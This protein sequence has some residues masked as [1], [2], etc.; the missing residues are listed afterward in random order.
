MIDLKTVA[1]V[2]A[3]EWVPRALAAGVDLGFALDSARVQC[4]AVLI[5]ELLANLMHNALEYAGRGAHVTVR[6]CTRD[7]AALIE[8]E[9]NGPGIARADRERV[10]ERFDRGSAPR[11]AG[12]GLGLSI[13]HDIA[14]RHGGSVEL[15][16]GSEGKGLLVRVRLPLVA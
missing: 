4:R 3:R 9:D 15:L 10:F 8:V 12:S 1:T 11:G 16:D 13:V 6:T 7:G 5:E 14:Q 2:V